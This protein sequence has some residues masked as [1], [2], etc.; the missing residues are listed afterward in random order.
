MKRACSGELRVSDIIG[1]SN[2]EL[3]IVG[4]KTLAYSVEVDSDA[5]YN[6][7]SFLGESSQTCH[8]KTQ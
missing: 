4:R 2:I 1:N 3:S 7:V 6:I 8:A 5:C